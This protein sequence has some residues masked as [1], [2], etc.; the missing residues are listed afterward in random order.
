LGGFEKRLPEVPA[1]G[2]EEVDPRAATWPA[3]PFVVIISITLLY[4]DAEL[5][6]LLVDGII[7]RAL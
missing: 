3:P 4:E 1:D 7:I 6:R 5:L 2:V